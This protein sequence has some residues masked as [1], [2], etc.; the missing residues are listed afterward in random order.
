M[1]LD[2]LS[3]EARTPEQIKGDADLKLAARTLRRHYARLFEAQR[4]GREGTGQRA[5]PYTY[6]MLATGDRPASSETSSTDTNKLAATTDSLVVTS[7]PAISGHDNAAEV[8]L[9]CAAEV[10]YYAGDGTPFCDE[11]Q[12]EEDA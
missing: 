11:H 4:C 7:W 1:L 6:R 12:P 2:A 3:E 10:T 9:T 8:C 5:L